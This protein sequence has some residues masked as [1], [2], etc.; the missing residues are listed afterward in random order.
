MQ[1]FELY[2]K[3]IND[4]STYV[5]SFIRIR[6]D[7]ISQKVQEALDNGHLWPEPLIQ[8]NPSFESG[9]YV[10]ELVAKGEL[11]PECAKIFRI[12]KGRIMKDFQCDCIGIRLMPMLQL[13]ET[14]ITC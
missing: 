10:D 3:L 8:L 14:K 5:R 11:H 1:V 6:D 4:Y 9:G 7:R 13:A 2:Q 12:N